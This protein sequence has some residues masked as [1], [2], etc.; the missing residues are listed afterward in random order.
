MCSHI[1]VVIE[2]VKQNLPRTTCTKVIPRN[3]IIKIHE[4]RSYVYTTVR[5]LLKHYGTTSLSDALGFP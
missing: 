3:L 1:S 4:Y 2:C 5:D